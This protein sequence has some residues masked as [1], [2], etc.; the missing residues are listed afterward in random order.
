MSLSYTN[1][2]LRLDDLIASKFAT[3]DQLFKLVEDTTGKVF[4]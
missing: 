1:A 2:K 4:R 3:V